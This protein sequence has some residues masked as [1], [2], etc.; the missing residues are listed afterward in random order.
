M[1]LYYRKKIYIA[2]TPFLFLFNKEFF[3]KYFLFN[4]IYMIF[5]IN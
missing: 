2:I 5:S 1:V 4:N 3:F